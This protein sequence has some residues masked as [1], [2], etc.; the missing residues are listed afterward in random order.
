M[1]Q[2]PA[3]GLCGWFLAMEE[4]VVDVGPELMEEEGAGIDA[5]VLAPSVC[6][7]AKGSLARWVVEV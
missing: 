2:I 4:R 1:E 5:D 6:C 7:V 3:L